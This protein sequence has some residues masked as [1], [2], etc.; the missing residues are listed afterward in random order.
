MASFFLQ[1][2]KEKRID[3]SSRAILSIENLERDM[4]AMNI[5]GSQAHHPKSVQ[6]DHLKRSKI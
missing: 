6:E 4:N 3:L 2:K 5:Y 1:S